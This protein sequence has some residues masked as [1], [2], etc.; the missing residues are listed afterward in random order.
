[1]K[2]NDIKRLPMAFLNAGL[3]LQVI[4]FVCSFVLAVAPDAVLRFAYVDYKGG[5]SMPFD[6]IHFGAALITTVLFG[7]MYTLLML[8]I[9]KGKTLGLGF[10]VLLGIMAYLTY[11]L[12][13]S[14]TTELVIGW[15]NAV[16]TDEAL[17]ATWSLGLEKNIACY[18]EIV[19]CQLYIKF[20]LKTAIILVLVAYGVYAMRNREQ[21][22]PKKLYK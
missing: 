14:V 2:Q 15:L 19:K 13:T 5:Y 12:A 16:S 10:G 6:Y 20:A 1:M 3:T 8:N 9:K 17:V 18:T 21:N 11:F 22:T 7:I 4:F